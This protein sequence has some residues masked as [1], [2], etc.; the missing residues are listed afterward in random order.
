[1]ASCEKCWWDAAKMARD[2]LGD[3]VELYHKLLKQRDKTPCSPKEQ[4][5]DYWNE[6]KQIDA[7]KFSHS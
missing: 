5:G 3:R 1:M 4:A 7:R 2:G 6:E